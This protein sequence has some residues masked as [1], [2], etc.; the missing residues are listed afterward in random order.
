MGFRRT[1][2]SK[3]ELEAERRERDL[4]R[5]IGFDLRQ[6]LDDAGITQ[7]QLARAAHMSQAQVSR[8]LAG[9]E[10][11]SLYALA[12][13]SVALD[14]RLV[15]RIE[16]NT[17]PRIRDRIQA[18]ILEALIRI[19]HARWKRFIEVPVYRPVRGV[20][21]SV[22]HD[23]NQGVAI[24]AE[25]HSQIRRFEQQQRWANAKADALLNG[26][27]LPLAQLTG[28]RPTVSRLLILRSTQAN[29]DLTRTLEASFR[30]AYP[31]RTED[32]VRA[33]TTAD[34]PWP[35]PSLIWARVDGTVAEILPTPPRGV[36]VG[37]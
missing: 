13:M 28:E 4:R 7:A 3:T 21:D 11:P 2:S 12:A 27:E 16:P 33:L 24:A 26:S 30:T 5:A 10:S 36:V 19:L 31:G 29:R 35:G 25:I 34:A 17:G 6:Q 9:L 23:P 1:G 20:I 37:R 14:G 18:R 32:A 8:I 15:M 22:L